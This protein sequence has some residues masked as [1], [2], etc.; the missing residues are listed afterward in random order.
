VPQIVTKAILARRFNTDLA[1][2]LL[3]DGVQTEGE[4]EQKEYR[5]TTSTWGNKP[6]HELEFSQT[7]R[8]IKA[9][10]ITNDK[11]YF[12][13]HEGTKVRYA[14]LSRD[15]ISKTTPRRLSSGPGRGRVLFIS[16]KHPRPGI[17]A[18][19]W[20]DVIIQKRKKPFRKNMQNVMKTIANL[21]NKQRQA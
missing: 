5:K 16:K 2:A 18:R 6:K 14:V 4:T 20:T 17:E 10:N 15:W 7:K 9:I 13:L 1:L 3:A 21:H 8:E 11:V 12:F 19:E